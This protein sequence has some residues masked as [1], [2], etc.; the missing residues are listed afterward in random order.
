[1]SAI[2]D[3]KIV[4]AENIAISYLLRNVPAPASR[5][6]TH[7]ST[8]A[9][10]AHSKDE[11]E[12]IPAL[13]LEEDTDSGSLIVIFAVNKASYND[14]E[15]TI[16]CIKQGFEPIF[17]ILV[18]VSNIGNQIL[19]AVVSMCL[20]RILSRLRMACTSRTSTKRLLKG[21]LQEV[22]LAVKIIR[23]RLNDGSLSKTADNFTLRAKEHIL[24]LSGLIGTIP[25]RDMSPSARRSLLNI[26]SKVSRYWEVAR[27]LYRT[28]KKSPLARAMR[29]IPVRLPEEAFTS[30]VIKG[31]F[32]ELQSKIAEASLRGSQEKL[33]REI[34]AI[35]KI[36]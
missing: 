8:L 28:A 18:S 36:S 17:A 13:C 15:D 6:R 4:C 25:N 16:R 26:V 21:T 7:S 33:L 27:Y 12:H 5:N 11:V 10:I 30:L 14:G 3:I 29:T 9:L 34:C 23:R 1:M 2:S 22:L 32:S 35:L 20:S 19:I 31:Y 24:G